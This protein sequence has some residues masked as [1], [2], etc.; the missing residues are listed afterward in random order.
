[1]SAL[2]HPQR[3]AA[4]LHAKDHAAVH[5]VGVDAGVSRQRAPRHGARHHPPR[6][7]VV[8]GPRAL[9]HLRAAAQGVARVVLAVSEP[10]PSGRDLFLR[11]PK[12]ER[13]ARKS[14]RR[15]RGGQ[16]RGS[17]PISP[18]SRLS[19]PL[20]LAA[21]RARWSRREIQHPG[22]RGSG[23]EQRLDVPQSSPIQRDIDSQTGGFSMMV[24]SSPAVSNDVTFRSSGFS[25]DMGGR[26]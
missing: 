17:Y 16:A 7:R 22:V 26:P 15:A 4:G 14:E 8:G 9:D 20:P 25:F 12:T 3:Q 24:S 11:A 19:P 18:P 10:A 2:P 6:Q 1:M 5:A 21:L 23:S 13:P